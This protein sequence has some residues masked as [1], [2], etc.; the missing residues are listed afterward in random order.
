MKVLWMRTLSFVEFFSLVLLLHYLKDSFWNQRRNKENS[1]HLVVVFLACL[2][3]VD[4]CEVVIT[5]GSHNLF[6]FAR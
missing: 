3:W 1:S 6:E 4:S 5:V 2:I